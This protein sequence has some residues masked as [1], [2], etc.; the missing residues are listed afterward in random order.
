MNTDEKFRSLVSFDPHKPPELL[1]IAERRAFG[2][3]IYRVIRDHAVSPELAFREGRT[4][5]SPEHPVPV[6]I[7][8]PKAPSKGI[9]IYFHGGGWTTGSM[10]DVEPHCEHVC[11]DAEVTVINVG[12]RLAPENPF[13]A[14]VEDAFAVLDWADSDRASLACDDAPIIVAGTSAGANI[15]TAV[16]A[17]CRDR[18]G[19]RIAFQYLDVPALDATLSRPS[20]TEANELAGVMK[21]DALRVAYIEYLGEQGSATH[22]YVSPLLADDVSRL[23]P[24]LIV[25]AEYDPLR[26]EGEEYATRLRAAGVDAFHHRYPGVNH[27]FTALEF[28]H[29]E[30]GAA[31]RELVAAVRA[32]V[33]GQSPLSSPAFAPAE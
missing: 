1:D 12:Y 16:A 7:Y 20:V 3:E 30:P 9:Y 15:A 29:P 6:R 27:G 2:H 26:D 24:A 13:P 14:A 28:L 11:A 25:T 33:A 10:D 4:V 23:P 21:P 31:H 32:C 18:C 19:P 8:R 22:R 5:E 17:M